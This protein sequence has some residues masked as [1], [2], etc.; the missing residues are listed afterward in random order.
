ML[1]WRRC[2]K[3]EKKFDSELVSSRG[4]LDEQVRRGDS[5]KEGGE[6]GA[7]KLPGSSSSSR[8]CWLLAVGWEPMR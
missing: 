3:A 6:E 2:G 8:S 4:A 1:R 5:G 7:M